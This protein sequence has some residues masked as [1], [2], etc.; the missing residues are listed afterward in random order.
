LNY[1]QPFYAFR[2]IYSGFLQSRM[3]VFTNATPYA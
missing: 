3:V 2:P 1:E